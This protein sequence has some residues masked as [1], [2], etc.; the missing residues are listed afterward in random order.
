ML[1]VF[2]MK[3]EALHR[4]REHVFVSFVR[5]KMVD[6]SSPLTFLEKNSIYYDALK[7]N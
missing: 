5:D 1:T 6:I 4:V 7:L 2:W 3:G